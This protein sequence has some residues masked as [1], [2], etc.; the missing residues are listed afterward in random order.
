MT[1]TANWLSGNIIEFLK[2]SIISLGQFLTWFFTP[3]DELS[4]YLGMDV[5]PASLL[6][7]SVIVVILGF[8]L[9]RLFIGG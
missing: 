8:H 1:Q 5:S 3:W 9:I 6:S 4:G 7:F 2:T